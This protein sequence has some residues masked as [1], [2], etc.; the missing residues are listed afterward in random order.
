MKPLYVLH[1]PAA[2]ALGEQIARGLGGTALPLEPGS[3]Q[4]RF[5]ELWDGAGAL[6]LV[7][8]LP[9]AVRAAGPLL[10]DKATD[11]AVLC[12]S[13]DGGTVLVV[14]GGHLGGEATWRSAAP[15]SWGRGGSPPPPRTD[16]GWWPRTDGPEDRDWP[17]GVG[18]PCRGF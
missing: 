14:A 17:F 9:V 2:S 3:L 11:P 15:P 6:I 7:G 5:R 10:R 8:S 12:V 13:E 16:R 4:G 1:A 18:R